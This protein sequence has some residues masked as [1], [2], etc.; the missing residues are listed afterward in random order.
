[1]SRCVDKINYTARNNSFLQKMQ[2]T[3]LVA[4][5]I[6]FQMSLFP[7]FLSNF[8][9]IVPLKQA[10]TVCY[11]CKCR[12]RLLRVYIRIEVRVFYSFGRCGSSLENSHFSTMACN[13]LLYCEI[14]G[15][16]V[17]KLENLTSLLRMGIEQKKS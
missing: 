1:M 10:S 15:Y 2:R 3:K 7:D 12:E 4:L 8:F 5:L 11:Y 16:C 14:G 9:K 6:F 13:I 17:L